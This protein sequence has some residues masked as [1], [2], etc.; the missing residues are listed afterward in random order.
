MKRGF[1]VFLLAVLV[2]SCGLLGKG[3]KV[4]KPRTHK[5]WARGNRYVIDI[6]VGNRH[7]RMFE[8][9]RTKMVRM[10]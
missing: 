3:E 4:V 7:I 10:K 5:V 6:P 2:S 1:F 9:K 8:R